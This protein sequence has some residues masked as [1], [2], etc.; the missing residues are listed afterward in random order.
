MMNC[1]YNYNYKNLPSFDFPDM[2]GFR[3]S[4]Y[5][6]DESGFTSPWEGRFEAIFMRLRSDNLVGLNFKF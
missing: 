2:T 1:Y 6:A 5:W 3:V 4:A